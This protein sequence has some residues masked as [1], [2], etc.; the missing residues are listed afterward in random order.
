[1]GERALLLTV[2]PPGRGFAVGG[3]Y[4]DEEGGEG[5][6]KAAEEEEGEEDRERLSREPGLAEEGGDEG[7]EGRLVA[8]GAGEGGRAEERSG[9]ALGGGDAVFSSTFCSTRP[10]ARFAD[11]ATEDGRRFWT[12][13]TTELAQQSRR[14]VVML[15]V[16]CGRKGRERNC[17][18][19]KREKK[20]KDTYTLARTVPCPAAYSASRSPS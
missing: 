12:E 6:G 17:R 2:L 5:G 15:G 9:A 1:M 13:C 16:V 11:F 14:L 4:V 18:F 3:E 7:L 19:I 8:T 10:P 20:E